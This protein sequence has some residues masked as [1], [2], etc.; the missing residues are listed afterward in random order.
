VLTEYEKTY[1]I[2]SALDFWGYN[3][4]NFPIIDISCIVG[5]GSL[6]L[7]AAFFILRFWHTRRK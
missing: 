1:N 2:Q 3:M 7:V 6:L 4:N 5:I